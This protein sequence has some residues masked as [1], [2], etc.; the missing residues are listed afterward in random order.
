MDIQAC[1]HAQTIDVD[2]SAETR[3]EITPL[4]KTQTV[5]QKTALV[6]KKNKK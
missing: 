5:E 6:L 2:V 4:E 1:T 3:V